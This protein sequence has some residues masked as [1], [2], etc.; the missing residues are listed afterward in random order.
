MPNNTPIENEFVVRVKHG[1]GQNAKWYPIIGPATDDTYGIVKLYD[2]PD[3]N[4]NAVAG[5]T[6]LTP[7]AL[8][9]SLLKWNDRY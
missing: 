3:A 6:A 4:K 7:A 1:S 2:T 8:Y 9:N 5:K